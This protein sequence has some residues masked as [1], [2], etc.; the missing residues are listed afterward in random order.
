MVSAAMVN[1]FCRDRHG[2]C[3]DSKCFLHVHQIKLNAFTYKST[4]PVLQIIFSKISSIISTTS[5]THADLSPISNE[6]I[7]DITH[8]SD[9]PAD[10]LEKNVTHILE[11]QHDCSKLSK[12]SGNY[13]KNI[14]TKMKLH[15]NIFYFFLPFSIFISFFIS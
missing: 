14:Y 4:A 11:T 12:D 6:D 2:F 7:P 13:Y 15:V 10:S 1:G 3:W 5:T 9:V 8:I